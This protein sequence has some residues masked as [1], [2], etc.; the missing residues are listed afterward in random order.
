MSALFDLTAER[1]EHH[2]SLGRLEARGTLRLALKEAGLDPKR[3]TT[4]ELSVVFDKL[5][6]TELERRGVRDP[7]LA[8]R[9]TLDDVSSLP[10]ADDA[11]ATGRPDEVFRR[12]AGD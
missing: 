3:L 2:T 4:G 7:A 8:C 5:M 9:H 11:R 6:V 12:L 10:K 1:L